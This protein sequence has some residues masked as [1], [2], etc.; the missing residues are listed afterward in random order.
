MGY[1]TDIDGVW[2]RYMAQIFGYQDVEDW[3]IDSVAE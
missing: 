2:H 3:G 1:G